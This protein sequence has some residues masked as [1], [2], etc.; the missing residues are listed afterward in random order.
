MYANK[1]KIK[2]AESPKCKS[3]IKV[4]GITRDFTVHAI[5][6]SIYIYTHGILTPAKRR[7]VVDSILSDNTIGPDISECT[8][9]F[10]EDN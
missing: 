10:Y 8:R 1:I 9:F 4:S 7:L 2:Y 3:P 6:H 5:C